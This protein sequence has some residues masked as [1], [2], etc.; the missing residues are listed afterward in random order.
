MQLLFEKTGSERDVSTALPFSNGYKTYLQSSANNT[1]VGCFKCERE[2][3]G[4]GGARS[5]PNRVSENNRQKDRHISPIRR[6][7]RAK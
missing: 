2:S 7:V 1:S 6:F 5:L 4:G 3:G